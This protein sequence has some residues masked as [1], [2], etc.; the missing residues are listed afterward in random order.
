M[1]HTKHA[2]AGPIVVAVEDTALHPE[3]VHL[4]AATG[5]QVIDAPDEPTLTRHAHHAFAV[6]ADQ[7]SALAV[8]P[9]PNI[10][11]VT[12]DIASTSPNAFIL[13]AQSVDLLKALGSLAVQE[14]APSTHGKVIAVLGA[15]GG[16]GAST[17]AAAICRSAPE[18]TLI[19][20]HRFSGGLDLILGIEEAPGARWGEIDLGDGTVAREDLRRALPT[21]SD[22][23]AVLTFA[24]TT[25][26]DPFVLGAEDVS[27]AVRAVAGA[28]VTVV[29]TPFPLLP[30]AC[31]LAVIVT[32]PELRP[33]SAAARLV[34]ECNAA[35][36][37]HV[38]LL[39]DNSWAA[40][41]PDEVEH[42]TRGRVIGRLREVRGFTATVEK[43]GLPAKLPRHLA[44]AAETVL[45]EV[46]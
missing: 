18:P 41:T 3:A 12:A 42:A 37:P 31:D 1:H 27:H 17:L 39:R 26:A 20:A 43:A 45:G 11:T 16:V 40:F 28:G 33:V 8:G 5:R 15:G 30:S 38:V 35:G 6:L 23:I 24:R 29:D 44:H 4:A 25:V 2:Q 32:V 22:G 21:T 46:A 10:F 7:R 34:A 9:G 19:D 13:P 14:R 36:V